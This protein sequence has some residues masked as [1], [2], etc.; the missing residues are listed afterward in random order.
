[1]FREIHQ[2]SRSGKGKWSLFWELFGDDPQNISAW[3]PI[4]SA[5]PPPKKKLWDCFIQ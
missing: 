1:M 3:F 5:P 2:D 4:N